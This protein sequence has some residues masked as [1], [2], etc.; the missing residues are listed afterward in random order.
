MKIEIEVENLIN[1]EEI[2]MLETIFNSENQS[3][4]INKLEGIGKAA[5]YEYLE[6]ILGK[7]VPT[8]ANEIKERRL[9]HL[10]KHHFDGSIPSE[11]EVASLF[12][13]TERR[14]RTLLRNVRTKF[15]F[16]LK[17]EIEDTIKEVLKKVEYKNDEYRVVITNDNILEE[18]KQ[19]VSSEAPHL[20]QIKKVRNSA[21]VQKIP[22]DTLEV[23]CKYYGVDFNEIIDE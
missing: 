12:Q 3:D 20:Y 9:F 6:M 17:K 10:L 23:L 7:Q 21:G 14:S 13:L 19:T 18:L 22:E 2:E 4:L 15:K 1:K 5:L 11:S 8:R 16:A